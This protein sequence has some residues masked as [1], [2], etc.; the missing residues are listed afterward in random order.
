MILNWPASGNGNYSRS[1]APFVDYNHDG[2]YNAI[3][4]DYPK[5][6]GAQI[7]MCDLTKRGV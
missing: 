4:G 3:D 1:L 6:D 7:R 5:I 2:I